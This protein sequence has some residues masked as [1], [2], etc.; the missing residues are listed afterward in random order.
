MQ[1]VRYWLQSSIKRVYPGTEAVECTKIT[2]LTARNDQVSFQ[3]C[4]RNLTENPVHVQLRVDGADGLDITVRRV[5]YVPLPHFTPNV[6]IEH[7][8]GIGQLPGLA[9][10]PL[11][12]E[13]DIVAGPFETQAFWL[14][15]RVPAE[16]EPKLRPLSVQFFTNDIL[17]SSLTAEIDTRPLIVKTTAFPVIQWFYADSLCD[18]YK[19]EPYEPKFWPIL[20]NYIRDL[21]QHGCSSLYVPIITPPTDGIKR[22]H[23]LLK[24]TEPS[25]GQYEFDFTDVE[26][27]VDIGL[28]QGVQYFEWTHWFWQWG[29]QWALRVYRSNAD[30]ESLLWPHETSATSQTY[31]NF[32]SQLFPVLK[33]F[34]DRKGIQDRSFFHVSDE[35]HGVEHMNNYKA[36]RQMLRELAPWMKVMDAL[37]EVEYGKQK[38]TDMPV[39]SISVAHEY[40]AAGIPSWVYYC[41]GPRGEYLNRFL[42]TPLTKI[43]MHGWLFRKLNALGFLHWGYNYWYA[44]GSQRMI[45]PFSENAAGNWPGWSS[46]DPFVVY[47]GVEGPIDSIRWEIF[48]ESLRDYALLESAGIESDDPILADIKGYAEFPFTEEWLTEARRRVIERPV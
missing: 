27:W 43:K 1:S 8:E 29:V 12:P 5:G 22:P 45:D 37:S 26:K 21:V 28:S 17:M 9:P 2:M 36:A 48:G 40:A 4:V 18:W 46:G 13:S 15:V 20:E 25:V 24:V 38:L 39:P 30:R 31:R 23:Q 6:P 41:C 33:Q 47:P 42:D 10:D 34:L 16:V 3:A 14:T 32:L 35:P 11:F 7:I 44:A 19:L